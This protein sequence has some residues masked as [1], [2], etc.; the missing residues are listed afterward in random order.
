MARDDTA[1]GH[2]K[3][4]MPRPRTLA[5]SAGKPHEPP[6]SQMKQRSIFSKP[7][8]PPPS[9]MKQRSMPDTRQKST[10]SALEPTDGETQ[11]LLWRTLRGMADGDETWNEARQNR[12]EAQE[13]GE[14]QETARE[15]LQGRMPR[16]RTREAQGNH[17]NP[18]EPP[19][20]QMKGWSEEPARY[21]DRTPWLHIEHHRSNQRENTGCS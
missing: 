9:Q 8:E 10:P 18:H 4:R 3:G 2:L 17:T 14:R 21:P 19:Q 6:P 5:R 1:R 20:L 11:S 13:R 7:H 12:D 16:P 15:H